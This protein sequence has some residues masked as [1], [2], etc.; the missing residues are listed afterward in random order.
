M[1]FTTTVK[2]QY[3]AEWE[4]ALLRGDNR[5]SFDYLKVKS[6]TPLYR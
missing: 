4:L 5:C 6:L 1:S 2:E 3:S